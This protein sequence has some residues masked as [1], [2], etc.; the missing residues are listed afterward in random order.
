MSKEKDS[1]GVAEV[2]ECGVNREVNGPKNTSLREWRGVDLKPGDLIAYIPFTDA[3]LM[4]GFEKRNLVPYT[5]IMAV[6]QS[7]PVKAANKAKSKA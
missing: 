7:V 3:I 6:S 4:D 5:N 1:V 2:I